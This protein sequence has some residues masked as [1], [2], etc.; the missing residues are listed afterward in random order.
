MVLTVCALLNFGIITSLQAYCCR[1][2]MLWTWWLFAMSI[3][4]SIM[5]SGKSLWA[6]RCFPDI[7]RLQLLTL[8]IIGYDVKGW[9]EL[10]S[11]IYWGTTVWVCLPWNIPGWPKHRLSCLR[12]MHLYIA[13]CLFQVGVHMH[14]PMCTHTQTATHPDCLFMCTECLVHQLLIDYRMFFYLGVFSYVQM[15]L[16]K[17]QKEIF[18]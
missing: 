1:N 9:W 11:G 16:R 12:V 10:Q 15:T 18:E 5:L 13:L 17:E 8:C 2:L 6:R 14:A 4:L 3:Y 7:D